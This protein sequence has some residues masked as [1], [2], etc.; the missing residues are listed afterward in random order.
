[1]ARVHPSGQDIGIPFLP[2]PLLSPTVIHTCSWVLVGGE[3][4]S[5]SRKQGR[6]GQMGVGKGD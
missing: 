5:S 3:A 4:L 6:R 2:S 1:M